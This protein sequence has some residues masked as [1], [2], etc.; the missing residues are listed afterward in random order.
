VWDHLLVFNEEIV[1]VAMLLSATYLLH[2]KKTLMQDDY[3]G[4]MCELHGVSEMNFTAFFRI[5]HQLKDQLKQV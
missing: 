5:A 2:K 1:D 4:V 3:E